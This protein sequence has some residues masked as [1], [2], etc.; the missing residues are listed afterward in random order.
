MLIIKYN[1]LFRLHC[2]QSKASQGLKMGMWHFYTDQPVNYK[3]FCVHKQA[4]RTRCFSGDVFAF[5]CK[6]TAMQENPTP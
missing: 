2:N 4:V 5:E 1:W 6:I 3:D